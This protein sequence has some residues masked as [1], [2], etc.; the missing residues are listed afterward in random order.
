MKTCAYPNCDK[1]VTN[2]RIVCCGMQHQRQYNGLRKT[3][4]VPM[5]VNGPKVAWRNL[6]KIN[7]FYK[8]AK[9]LTEET[10]IPHEVDHIVPVHSRHV[11]GLHNEFNLRVIPGTQNRRK[12]NTFTSEV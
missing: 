12:G 5:V 9:R 11:C 2:W 7:A 4:K 6:D 3:N 1:L 10:G 8:E